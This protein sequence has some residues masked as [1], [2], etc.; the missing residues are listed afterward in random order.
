MMVVD[1]CAVDLDPCV[2]FEP[3]VVKG[4]TDAD[5]AGEASLAHQEPEKD[6]TIQ[7]GT[8]VGS[9]GHSLNLI[10]PPGG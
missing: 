3:V 7:A 5:G 8:A 9:S 6:S 10:H 4:D 2:P 1:D